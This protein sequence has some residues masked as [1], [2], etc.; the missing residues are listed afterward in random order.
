MKNWIFN[1]KVLQLNA[2][3]MP[4]GIKPLH[5]F[6]SDMSSSGTPK[7]AL[8][9]EYELLEDGNPNFDLVAYMMPIDWKDW[10]ALKPR[11]FD[12]HTIHTPNMTIRI[13]TVGIT[14][15][16]KSMPEKRFSLSRRS[17]YERDKGICAYTKNPISYSNSSI[18]HIVPKSK[19]INGQVKHYKTGNKISVESWENKVICSKDINRAKGNKSL[20]E[21]GF[22]LEN[23]PKEPKPVPVWSLIREAIHPDWRHFL[24][25][26]KELK[27]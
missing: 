3:W 15:E 18:D 14:P 13:P 6:I 10:I 23:E 26:K 7:K 12:E 5:M 4:I 21:C 8:Q 17:L 25:N 16:Y 24:L 1:Q 11:K 27:N 22:T 20:D 9:I 2:N 19:A